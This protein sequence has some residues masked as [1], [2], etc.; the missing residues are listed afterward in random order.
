MEV[1]AKKNLGQHFLIDQDIASRI[2]GL[3]TG[4]FNPEL[5]IEIGPGTGVLTQHLLKPASWRFLA[6]DVDKESIDFL[7]K[8][9]PDNADQ[10]VLQDFM[11]LNS[12]TLEHA[13][14]LG[15]LQRHFQHFEKQ[16]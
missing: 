16:L 14:D 12:S 9:W 6:A 13:D 1:R 2:V 3:F 7:K 4:H 8:T 11:Q 5:L 15:D 10:F